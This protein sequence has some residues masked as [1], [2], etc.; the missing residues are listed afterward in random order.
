[1][2]K[3]LLSAFLICLLVLT[4]VPT[5]FAEYTREQGVIVAESLQTLET[6]DAGISRLALNTDGIALKNK[7]AVRWI[8][9]MELDDFALDFYDV[10]DEAS[11][12]DGYK[13]YLIEDKY[14]SVRE[15]DSARD[16]WISGNHVWI[17][18]SGYTDGAV[19]AIVAAVVPWED[20][21][22]SEAAV[23]ACLR[24]INAAYMSY[25]HDLA[26]RFWRDTIFLPATLY[27]KGQIYIF[28]VLRRPHTDQKT[29]FDLR[30]ENYR[31]EKK[32]RAAKEKMDGNIAAICSGVADRMT[33][34]EKINYF[35]TWLTE[36][37]CYNSLVAAGRQD[38]VPRVAWECVSALEGSI[39]STGPVC[40][41]YARAFKVLCDV[42]DIPCVLVEGYVK[43][44][45]T[46]PEAEFHMW[47]YVKMEDGKWYAVDVTWN[48][49][50]VIG[51]PSKVLSGYETDRWLLLGEQSLL[52]SNF[53]LIEAHPAQNPIRSAGVMLVNGPTLSKTA[54]ADLTYSG[55]PDTLKSGSKVTLTADRLP[56]RK[57]EYMTYTYAVTSGTLP[58]GL[59]LNKNTGAIT[60]TLGQAVS[61][62]AVT[63]TVYEDG[64]KAA[65][66]DIV[67][68]EAH[69]FSTVWSADAYDHWHECTE[70]GARKDVADHSWNKGKVTQAATVAKDGTK[71]Y[72]CTVCGQIKN[73]RIPKTGSSNKSWTNPFGDVSKRDWF[74]ESVKYTAQ[75]G[76][77]NGVSKTRFAPDDTTTRAMIVT[78]L[79]RLE[80]SP[81]ASG[82]RFTD[83]PN[84]TWYTKAVSW[85][86]VRGI[87]EG[88]GGGKFGPDDLI[89]REQMA[90]FLYRYA[91]YRGDNVSRLADLNGYKDAGQIG[92]WAKTPMRWAN[93]AGLIT[94]RTATTLAPDGSATRAE[95]ATI[96]MRFCKL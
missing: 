56:T 75:N 53:T 43:N 65:A 7:N 79:Y 80:G 62:S 48:D 96:L 1:M 13:D 49:P 88:Y 8:D 5:A 74:Y 25:D 16:E 36:H 69:H 32:I 86:S 33:T 81:A 15:Q 82:S 85:A 21:S 12:F 30:S 18:L 84:G 28:F 95:V 11:D 27:Y 76:L 2:K 37:N 51:A 26:D 89:T 77:M 55:M 57:R 3:R 41:G 24:Q 72:T 87:V 90:A 46:D 40:E 20:E 70:C 61:K 52:E 31:T 17:K 50:G 91:K 22:S 71:T 38:E 14:F 68:H 6:A 10:L 93:K 29:D 66:C 44:T 64:K 58:K 54:Y 42:Y 9:R 4:M 83:V 67:F 78:I 73:E 47:N 34:F 45:R 59:S 23:D 94:G 35:N 19:P 39:G 60:G 92:S 63:V